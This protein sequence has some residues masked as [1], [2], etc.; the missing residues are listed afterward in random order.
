MEQRYISLAGLGRELLTPD[1][2]NEAIVV[3]VAIAIALVIGRIVRRV[4]VRLQAADHG[5]S[6]PW[7][8]PL[9]EAG[10][11]AAPYV[12]AMLLIAA[13]RA[14]ADAWGI[15]DTVFVFALRLIGALATVRLLVYG[16]SLLLGDSSW[17][18]RSRS[19]RGR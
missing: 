2:L 19:S 3:L 17:V 7:Q 9:L 14:V 4:V 15:P 6:A 1:G 10:A 12:V 8:T 11:I 16:A 5:S 13:A 18:D